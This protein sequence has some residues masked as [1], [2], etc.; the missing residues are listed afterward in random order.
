MPFLGLLIAPSNKS[1]TRASMHQGWKAWIQAA[2]EE[3]GGAVPPGNAQGETKWQQVWP[4]VGGLRRSAPLRSA[5][6][7]PCHAPAIAMCP[8]QLSPPV[9]APPQRRRPPSRPDIR[10]TPGKGLQDLTCTVEELIDQ[11]VKTCKARQ[12]SSC[13]EGAIV[14]NVCAL[15]RRAVQAL[16]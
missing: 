16:E 5:P 6:L 11:V 9:S 13:F 12:F 10:L 7:T 8:A 4:M 2:V 3:L 14:S 15:C 1:N